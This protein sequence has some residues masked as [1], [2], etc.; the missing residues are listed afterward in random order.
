M[1]W[2]TQKSLD[3]R[4][5]SREQFGKLKDVNMPMRG[6]LDSGRAL[7]AFRPAGCL[8]SGEAGAEAGV[9]AGAGKEAIRKDPAAPITATPTEIA[10]RAGE[11]NA[12]AVRVKGACACT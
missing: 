10:P 11:V 1:L 3:H 7:G 5:G 9:G 12:I 2:M 4:L 6:W 8:G